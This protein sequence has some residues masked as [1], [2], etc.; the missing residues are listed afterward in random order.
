MAQPKAQS[1]SIHYQKTSQT[2]FL[3]DICSSYLSNPQDEILMV[4]HSQ[5]EG[6]SLCN[7]E[8]LWLSG[9]QQSLAH[10]ASKK[11]A[12]IEPSHSECCGKMLSPPTDCGW[13]CKGVF[14]TGT[15][16]YCVAWRE[17]QLPETNTQSGLCWELFAHSLGT[18]GGP[19]A[20]S[21]HWCIARWVKPEWNALG[22]HIGTCRKQ[23]K[24]W[25]LSAVD[26]QL[27]PSPGATVCFFFSRWPPVPQSPP[28]IRHP[29]DYPTCLAVDQTQ[30]EFSTL[31]AGARSPWQRRPRQ[32][33]LRPTES[34]FKIHCLY[35]ALLS[36]VVRPLADSSISSLTRRDCTPS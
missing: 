17:S 12:H 36:L 24:G 30:P 1:F 25:H 26:S 16:C 34:Q 8:R 6:S 11:N 29:G 7:T 13:L 18:D 23:N 5:G 22:N 21:W 27:L 31:V 20:S 32:V 28:A 3:T 9:C 2:G 35:E 4:S 33:A 10:Y 14:S 19:L 15:A